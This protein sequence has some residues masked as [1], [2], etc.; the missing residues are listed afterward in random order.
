MLQAGQ[1]FRVD[2][3]GAA[4]AHAFRNSVVSLSSPLP[5]VPAK[6]ITLAQGVK[7]A[8]VVLH[9]RADVGPR[10]TLRRLFTGLFALRTTAGYG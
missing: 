3:D 2:R 9:Q 7:D 10:Q 8:P 6:R 4:L 5:E 1:W